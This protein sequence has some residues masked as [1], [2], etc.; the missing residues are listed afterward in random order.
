MIAGLP[1]HILQHSYIT[2]SQ[3]SKTRQGHTT[4]PASQFIECGYQKKPLPTGRRAP[5]E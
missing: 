2:Q 5:L 3:D 4:Q 1:E